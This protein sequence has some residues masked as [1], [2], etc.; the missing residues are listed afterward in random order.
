MN[1]YLLIC[2]C[3]LALGSAVCAE[4]GREDAPVPV[5][6]S[7]VPVEGSREMARLSG[8]VPALQAA[9]SEL[10]ELRKL[11]KA[12]ATD[13]ERMEVEKELDAQ[14][15]RVAQLRMN[16]RTLAAGVEEGK[17]LGEE[18][19]EVSW[20][21]NL[22]DIIAP[23]SSGVRELTSG[24]REMEAL[25]SELAKWRER[26]GLSEAALARIDRLEGIA[27]SEAVREELEATRKLWA[28]RVDEAE[29]QIEVYSQQVEERERN[30]PTAW[31]M[32][33]G[34][35]AKFWRSKGMNLV[36][37]LGAAVVVYVVFRRGY[38]Q[39]TRLSP[40]HRRKRNG[41]AARGTDLMAGALAVF[42]A[43]LSAVV[44]FYLRGD[45]LLLALSIIFVVGI[46]WASKRAI[47]PYVEQI[48]MILNI[49]TVRQGERMVYEGI[50]WRV[51]RLNFYCDFSNPDLHGGTLRLPVRAVM[52]LHSR[53]P[54]AKEPWFPTRCD[55]WVLVGDGTYGKVVQQ[56]PEQVVVLQLGGS[57][58]TYPTA[59]FLTSQ[60]EN[61]SHGF[62]VSSVFGIDYGH[63]GISTTLVPEVLEERL[64]E[65]LYKLA[66]R[67][68]VKSVRVEFASAGASSLDYEVLVDFDGVVAPRFRRMR[69]AIQR[70]CVD[71][72]NERGWVIPFTQITVHEAAVAEAGGERVG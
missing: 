63:Q 34:A 48:K 65:E 18:E 9:E 67:E 51:D 3:C 31:N 25:R 56:T 23:V 69:R 36:M 29:S 10:A 44:V 39:L 47:P 45:W 50:P 5:E 14:R 68:H 19:Q 6:E 8:L 57:R 30:T 40:F 15:E 11:R 43:V 59:D 66:G 13:A 21:R 49:G 2:C 41:L 24:P 37:A 16:F 17:Y 4:N 38:R 12:A 54:D 70:V 20:Q 32:V 62:R 60:P 53:E 61:F 33:S 28:G 1:G 72:C 58:K 46:L 55:D 64:E 35:I 71:V 52:P 42:F 27:D 7:R 26:K 22:E